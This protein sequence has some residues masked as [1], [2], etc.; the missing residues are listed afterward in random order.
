MN[1]IEK[2]NEFC[3]ENNLNDRFAKN[4]HDLVDLNSGEI[5]SAILRIHLPVSWARCVKIAEDIDKANLAKFVDKIEGGAKLLPEEE[6][7]GWMAGE[8]ND[9]DLRKSIEAKT[10]IE[11]DWN[12]AHQDEPYETEKYSLKATSYDSPITHNLYLSAIKLSLDIDKGSWQLYERNFAIGYTLAL[13]LEK[14]LVDD[15]FLTP[16][17]EYKAT[18]QHK[19]NREL[20]EK[21]CLK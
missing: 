2:F 19:V 18:N 3:K 7:F 12:L 17:L 8:D 1:N 9:H 6:R 11:C 13:R 15:G 5:T 21:L 20:G 14:K 10:G 16:I 4:L